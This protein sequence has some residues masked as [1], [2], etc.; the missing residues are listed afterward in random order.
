MSDE[1]LSPE[2]VAQRLDV[3]AIRIRQL[4]DAGRLPAKKLGSVYA[5][6]EG[7]LHLI[8]NRRP[9]RPKSKPKG[10][11]APT[12]TTAPELRGRKGAR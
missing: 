11:S 8:E 12:A 10:E 9:G 7:D 1:I 5:I 4:I 6:R 2:E 3:S